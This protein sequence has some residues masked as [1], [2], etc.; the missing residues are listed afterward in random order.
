MRENHAKNRQLVK[1][2]VKAGRK[3]AE[4]RELGSALLVCEG[5][6]TEPFYLHGLLQHL[7]INAASVEIIEGQSK[8]NAVAVVNRASRRF[9]QIPRDRV[10]VLVDAEQAD[11]ARALKLCKVPLQRANKKKGL[12]MI[13]IEP[14]ISTPCFEVWLLLHFRY[15]DQT[16]RRFADVLPELQA[17]LP[18]YR[19]A[20]PRIFMKVGG[21]EGLERAVLHAARLRAALA[22]TASKNPVTDVDRLVEALRA[23]APP[24]QN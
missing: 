7:G 4:R 15:C 11:L 2:R 18:D 17:S 12:P 20:D 13:C 24:A 8:S 23:I 10:F 14:I 16:F 21:G 3:K 22:Q 6:C 1:E 19:K 9:E 5:E